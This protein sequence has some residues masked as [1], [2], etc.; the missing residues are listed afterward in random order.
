M[1]EASSR[2][3]CID[4][5]R[6]Y[7]IDIAGRLNPKQVA[8]LR[9]MLAPVL[10][11]E[12]VLDAGCNSGFVV[13]FLPRSCVVSG[14]DVAEHLVAIARGR[15]ARADVA[16]VEELPYEDQSVDVIILGEILE[17]VFDPVAVLREARRVA[18]R[19]V[20]GSV[21]NERSKWGPTGKHKPDGHAY[22][23]R[24]FTA[25]TLTKTLAAAG[26]ADVEVKAFA[27][28]YLFRGAVSSCGS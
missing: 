20:I 19:I 24:A 23:V 14:V 8:R 7:T 17:H 13:D 28:F 26:L 22:H 25:R 16:P 9:A 11:G 27:D 10:E 15:L 12:H 3:D 18:R 5:H 21:P 1:A 4:R 2:D 6:A